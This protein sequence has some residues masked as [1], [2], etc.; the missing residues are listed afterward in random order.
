MWLLFHLAYY[1]W[2][3]F[4]IYRWEIAW[5]IYSGLPFESAVH[6]IREDTSHLTIHEARYLLWMRGSVCKHWAEMEDLLWFSFMCI[7]V[8]A[9]KSQVFTSIHRGLRGHW[10]LWNWSNRDLWVALWVLGT[11]L[12]F[13]GRA[14]RALNCWDIS[15]DLWMK[16][17][18]KCVCL[19]VY[20]WEWNLDM[21]Y[22]RQNYNWAVSPVHTQ[23]LS[24]ALYSETESH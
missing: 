10:V 13:S 19:P 11:K 5:R 3:P 7:C 8:Y 14:A 9:S 22:T 23:T 17:C 12:W 20:C 1:I 6:Y 4:C 18:L 24:L 15:P 16:F 2:V 21:S